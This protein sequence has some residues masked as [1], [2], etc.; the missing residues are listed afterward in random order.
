[1]CLFVLLLKLT[2]LK[3]V[4]NNYFLKEPWFFRIYLI[5]KQNFIEIRNRNLFQIENCFYLFEMD[6]FLFQMGKCFSTIDKYPSYL[7]VNLV[8]PAGN[9]R[10]SSLYAIIDKKVS[11]PSSSFQ[12]TMIFNHQ[13][14]KGY[15]LI[16]TN[17][18]ICL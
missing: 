13:L 7:F 15:V 8:N 10:D 16:F 1:M 11:T 14:R 3:T 5:G 2:A 9:K 4:K 6:F 17:V 18:L 12:G